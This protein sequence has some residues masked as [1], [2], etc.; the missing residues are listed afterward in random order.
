MSEARDKKSS[1]GRL[2][3]EREHHRK[4]AGRAE[5]IWQWDSPTGSQRAR[6]RGAFFVEHGGLAPGVRALEI[7]CGTGVFLQLTAGSGASIDAVDLSIELLQ[8]AR[9]HFP[10]ESNVHLLCGNVERLPYP[11][12]SFDVVYGSSILHHL[13]LRPALLDVHRVLKPGGRIV[14]AEPNL[15]NPHIAF[16]FLLAPRGLFGLSDDEMAFTRFK[17]RRLLEELGF[18]EIRVTPYDFLYPLVPRALIGAV[19]RAGRVVERIPLV[20]E[21]AGSLLIQARR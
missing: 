21:I 10:F 12:A 18:S 13:N 3:R 9:R 11:D 2:R 4:I 5:E 20:R 7:G 1:T 17:A 16:T 15:M 8:Q 19:M 6:R 14:F